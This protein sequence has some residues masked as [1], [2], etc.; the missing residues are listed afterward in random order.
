M[1]KETLDIYKSELESFLKDYEEY[2]ELRGYADAKRE[3]LRKSLQRE[4]SLIRVIISAVHGG[5]SLTLR[6]K[7][8]LIFEQALSQSLTDAIQD[9]DSRDFIESHIVLVLNQAIGNIVNNT[10]PTQEISP[11]LPIMDE[12]LKKRC[13]YLLNSSQPLDTVL[14]ESTVILEDRL[15]GKFSHEKLSEIIPSSVDQMGETLVNKLL[16]PNDPKIVISKD[17]A[18]R[19]AFYKMMIGI[20]AYLRN[21][22]HH[23][24]DNKTK[25]SLAWSVVGLIDSLLTELDNCYVSEDIITNLSDGEAK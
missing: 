3:D 16:S 1:K 19:I 22:C 15:R 8:V 2:V 10:I 18:E 21:P 11:I 5:L 7:V 13:L 4:S 25:L 9:E 20:V 17:K 24:L 23:S 6:S 12:E 14:R